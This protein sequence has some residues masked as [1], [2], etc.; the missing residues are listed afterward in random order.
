MKNFSEIF[1]SG[2]VK[3]NAMRTLEKDPLLAF[4]FQ[5]SI[6]GLDAKIGFQKVSGL[7]RE[8]EVIEY[9]ESMYDHA[10]KLPGRE[11]FGEVTFERGIFSDSSMVGK[12]EQVF[13]QNDMRQSVV[14]SIMDRFKN[15]RRKFTLYEAWFSKYELADLD[16]TSSDVLIETLTLVYEDMKPE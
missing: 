16:A 13:K 11:S 10:H 7:S 5:V 9:F 15:V 6:A 12:Y 8:I 3:A 4:C 2:I 14:V 1:K